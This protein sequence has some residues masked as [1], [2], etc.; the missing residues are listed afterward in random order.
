[1]ASGDDE[2]ENE[3]D[4]GGSRRSTKTSFHNLKLNSSTTGTRHR[5][6]STLKLLQSPL[7]QTPDIMLLSSSLRRELS[8]S[9]MGSNTCTSLRFP[10]QYIP[11]AGTSETIPS[12]APKGFFFTAHP[13]NHQYQLKSAS[14]VRRPTAFHLASISASR[15]YRSFN[16]AYP[17]SPFSRA[18]NTG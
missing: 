16:G 10:M 1:M 5:T 13:P 8:R 17:S 2:V 7:L 4:D 11:H 3:R 9:H 12:S 18:E 14:A 15:T 6:S